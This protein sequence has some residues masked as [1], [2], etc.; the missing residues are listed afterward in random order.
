[1]IDRQRMGL[2][3]LAIL[4]L[5][6]YLTVTEGSKS[7]W[8][9]E[10]EALIVRCPQRGRS[11]YP[12]EWYYSDTNESIPTQ[13]RNRIF[14]SR[15][16]LKFL[17]ARVEDSGIYACVIRSPN[18]NKTGYLNVTIHKKPP[19]CNIPDYLMY[20]TVRGS[21]KNF[22]IT[23]PTIDLYNWT[24]PVQWFKNC[25]ALQEPRF[26]AHRSYLFIDNVTHDD[27]GDYTCQFTHSENGT[28][29]IVTATRSFTVEEKGFSM[30]PVITNPPYNHTMEVEIGKPASIA[31]S[32]CFGKGSH[33][34]ADVLWQINKT[35]VGNFGE[36][37]IQ[38]E[39]GRNE[40]SSNDMDCLTSV[41]RI[42]GVTEK[43]LSLEY[44]CLAL[45]LHGMIRHTIRLRR[46]QPI[47][48]RSIYYIV[49]G[50]SLLL[51]F[52]NVL[53]IVLKVFWIEVALFWRGIV[54]PYKTRNDG[55]LYDAYIIYPR[56]F[57][58]S[59]AGTRS[60]EYF[61]HHTLPDV[62]ENKC[63]YKLC[64]YGRDL[65]PGQDAA[66]VVEST[67]QNSR[68]QVFVLAPHMMHNKE[69]AY[70]QEIALHSALI[71]NNSKVILIEM[72]PLGEASRLQVGDLQDS[73]Q[74]LVKI[75]GTIK[76]RE[77]HVADKQ[78]LSSKFWKH[79]RYQMPV[80]E[81]ASK[82]ASI[83]A[84]LSGKACLDLKHF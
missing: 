24:A 47:D 28:N 56:V 23:C 51:M 9:L 65:L 38:E 32:A 36:A 22:K 81:R 84:P 40:S 66:T 16:R 29:Y 46:K 31:C 58:G 61:V 34:L 78:S 27:E 52:I 54:T 77:D 12:V 4:T 59:A 75:Q 39:E 68:R 63:G 82:M 11:T 41:L 25:K 55:K 14:V 64:I 15:D 49:A 6:M 2:W 43:D 5:P 76:W 45:N 60:V 48:H 13:K 57:R 50:C 73:L 30:F 19:S 3:A 1:M 79:V 17:P 83:A 42:T 69:F 37:R 44:D 70:E 72:E 62:L 10:N 71:Q 74:H 80:P 8:G 21:D 53:V 18:L 33:F 7:S 20:S 26:R 35:V 67:I